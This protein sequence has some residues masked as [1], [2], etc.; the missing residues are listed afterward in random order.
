MYQLGNAKDNPYQLI[1]TLLLTRSE[2]SDFFTFTGAKAVEDPTKKMRAIEAE[3]IIIFVSIDLEDNDVVVFDVLCTS[4][5]PQTAKGPAQTCYT[6]IRSNQG[7][8]L[9]P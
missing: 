9:V 3:K 1:I 7:T 4:L 5:R 8:D 2:V 6:S